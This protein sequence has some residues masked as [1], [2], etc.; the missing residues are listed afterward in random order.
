MIEIQKL[1]KEETLLMMNEY[2]SQFSKSFNSYERHHHSHFVSFQSFPIFEFNVTP[3]QNF[4]NGSVIIVIVIVVIIIIIGR[5]VI[6][7][8]GFDAI[9]DEI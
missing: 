9:K 3:L 7:I 6:S 1:S 4:I 8:I 2:M 5:A